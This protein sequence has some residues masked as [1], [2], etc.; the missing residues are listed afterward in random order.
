MPYTAFKTAMTDLYDA[1][2]AAEHSVSFTA[3]IME[4]D[5]TDRSIADYEASLDR[6]AAV[7]AQIGDLHNAEMHQ[8]SVD[9]GL[10]PRAAA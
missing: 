5:P 6:A 3:H 7:R 4:M 2:Y 1:L 8:R 9:A 10:V